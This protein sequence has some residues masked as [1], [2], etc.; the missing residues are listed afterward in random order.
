MA[1]VRRR[2]S[3]SMWSLTA[4]APIRSSTRLVAVLSLTTI[5]NLTESRSEMVSPLLNSDS[6]PDPDTLDAAETVRR[7]SQRARPAAT[8]AATAQAIGSLMVLAGQVHCPVCDSSTVA[9]L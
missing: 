8:C 1:R 2:S 7:S 5:I 6:T 9:R 4:S 3:E